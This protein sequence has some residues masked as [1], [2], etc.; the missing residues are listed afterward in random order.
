MRRVTDMKLVEARDQARNQLE[1]MENT[2]NK[3]R[4]ELKELELK[5][6]EYKDQ[7]I[8]RYNEE[9]RKGGL[10]DFIPAED[11]FDEYEKITLDELSKET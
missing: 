3:V 8:E 7:W 5:S 2:L 9:R 4:K 11:L 1:S 6:P 10:P